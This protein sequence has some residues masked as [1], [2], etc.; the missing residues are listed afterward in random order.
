MASSDS[1]A[2]KLGQENV[3][4]R[5]NFQTK[6]GIALT[7]AEFAEYQQRLNKARAP[8]IPCCIIPLV[9]LLIIAILSSTGEINI[10]DVGP[11]PFVI[12]V[13]VMFAGIGGAASSANQVSNTFAEEIRKR[14]AGIT[15]PAPGAFTGSTYAQPMQPQPMMQPQPYVSQQTIV[16]ETVVV[17]IRCQFCGGLV[18]QGLHECPVCG[19]KM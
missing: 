2:T 18:D 11:A 7:D 3:A 9:I 19:G 4:A 6:Y 17:K 16:K 8:G 12:L 10:D 14:R 13:I 15:T 1:Y 5:S